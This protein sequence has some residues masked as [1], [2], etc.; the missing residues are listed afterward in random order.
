MHDAETRAGGVGGRAPLQVNDE[1]VT[2]NDGPDLETLLYQARIQHRG[3]AALLDTLAAR[4]DVR[5]RIPSI[6]PCDIGWLSS[7][8]GMRRDPFTNK[9]T[10]HRGLDFSLPKGTPVRVTADG[11]VASV[12]KQRGLGRLVKV[13]HGNGVV[14][15][16]ILT[17]DGC[18]GTTMWTSCRCT[19]A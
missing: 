15:V 6:R 1:L 18:D 8:F 5:D 19:R 13:D 11:V 16:A 17:T 4:Q 10:F 7:R 3:M 12:E 2:V 9:Q 14:T